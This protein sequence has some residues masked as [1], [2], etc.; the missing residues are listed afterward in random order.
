MS[1]SPSIQMFDFPKNH[2]KKRPGYTQFLLRLPVET[3]EKVKR[4][5]DASRRKTTS[6]IVL[7]LEAS[8]ANES[9]DEHGVIVV[10]SST[11]LK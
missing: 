8:M 4:I 6:E 7:R 11:R 3:L 10:H 1:A 5:A 9:I 2:Q